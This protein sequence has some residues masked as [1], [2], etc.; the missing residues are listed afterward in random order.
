MSDDPRNTIQADSLEHF[1]S[2]E[3]TELPDLTNHY[4]L[5]LDITGLGLAGQLDAETQ[6]PAN[7]YASADIRVDQLTAIV[8]SEFAE[9][10]RHHLALEKSASE[11]KNLLKK[12]N[13]KLIEIVQ[14]L[15][16][17]AAQH[18]EDPADLRQLLRKHWA[19]AI[20]ILLDTLVKRLLN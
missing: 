1:A 15:M 5:D 20:S 10:K 16:S 9:L 6:T 18:K 7:L 19:C 3:G 14:Q 11:N 13:E 8:N 4:G 17:S 2:L 12:Q